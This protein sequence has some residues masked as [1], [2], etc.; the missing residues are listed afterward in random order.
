MELP[1]LMC[2]YADRF[3]ALSS[4]KHHVG[5]PLGAWLVLAL[6]APAASGELADEI[7][8]ALGADVDTAHHAASELLAHPHP[9]VSAAAAAWRRDGPPGLDQWLAT[10][11]A[12]VETGG[13]PTQDQADAW[14]RDHTLGLIHR[15]PLNTEESAVLLASALAARVTWATPFEIAD[16]ADLLGPWSTTLHRVLRASRLLGHTAFI[17]NTERA[18]LVAVHSALA[19]DLEV[20]SV[21]ADPAVAAA[22][23]LAAAHEIAAAEGHA[24]AGPGAVSL[25]DLPIGENAQWTI[26]EERAE[27]RGERVDALLP[28]WSASS[29]HDLLTEA[30]LGFVAAG[31][32]LQQ[33]AGLPHPA[34]AVQ[35][36]VA[37]YGRRGFEAAAVTVLGIPAS[38]RVA[39]PSGPYRTATLRFGHPYA[40]VATALGST[41]GDPWQGLPVFAAWIAEPDDAQD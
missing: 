41:P 6:A 38:G 7:A 15:F 33:L 21:I 13:V 22:D 8:D 18:G 9:A 25:F 26:T 27:E 11:P 34:K 24:R 1:A 39:R 35:S 30:S 14:A 4:G 29:E 32:A 28:A 20:T 19:D 10:L 5:S 16:A 23:V 40:V 36:A 31:D 3:A 17:A 37:R 12:E 2:R